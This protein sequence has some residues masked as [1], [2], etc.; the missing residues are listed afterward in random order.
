MQDFKAF[1]LMCRILDRIEKTIPIAG[2]LQVTCK[3]V[4]RDDLQG[5]LAL[6]G[7]SGE[8]QR[9]LKNRYTGETGIA[10][11]LAYNKETGR[12]TEVDDNPFV[13]ETTS[14]NS[15]GDSKAVVQGTDY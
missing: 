7:D 15:T 2:N 12:L 4:T 11:R 8:A 6:Q 1:V 13:E 9:V 5:W 14:D 10:C 3:D